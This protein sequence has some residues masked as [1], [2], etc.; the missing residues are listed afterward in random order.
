M[1]ETAKMPDLP[2]WK[3][4]LFGFVMIVGLPVIFVLGVEGVGLAIIHLKYGVPGKSYGLWQYDREL[5]AIHAA[6][7][8]N[9]DSETNNFGFRN[10][11]NVLEPKPANALRIIAYGGSTTYCYNLPNDLAWPLRLQQILRAQHNASDQVLNGGAIMWSIGHEFARAKR[12]LPT[13][14]PDVVIIYSGVNEEANAAL[15]KTEGVSLEQ[16]LKDGKTGLFSRELLQ[17]R[18]L[19]RNSVIIRYWEYVAT[20][21]WHSS[22]AG[23]A[24]THI[25]PVQFQAGSG[26]ID[27][28]VSQNFN[29]TLRD[30]IALIRAHGAK[31]IYVIMGGL[32]EIGVNGRLLQY[33]RQGAEVARQLNVIVLDSQEIIESFKGER[34]ALFFYTGVHWSEIGAGLLASFIYE[35]ALKSN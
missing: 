23:G 13:L 27:P 33:S 6:N 34:P 25:A 16:A 21:W 29:A 8:Y 28:V 11:E 22:N 35:R 31:P 19:M 24:E 32:P 7:A 1:I 3:Q 14:K 4:I 9:R 17:T 10:K 2:L 18:W 12:D 26:A 5:G 20:S 30:F 15:L